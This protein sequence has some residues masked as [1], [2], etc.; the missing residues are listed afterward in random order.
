MPGKITATITIDD[1]NNSIITAEKIHT[2]QN[3]TT[4]ITKDK[5]NQVHNLNLGIGLDNKEAILLTN[6]P[7]SSIN[8]INKIKTTITTTGA[9]AAGINTITQICRKNS[10]VYY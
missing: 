1:I 3:L 5:Y 8:E 7:P 6:L 9:Y 2:I 4:Q 10:H